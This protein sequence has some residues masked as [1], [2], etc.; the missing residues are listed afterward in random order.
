MKTTSFC[1]ALGLALTMTGLTLAA[2]AGPCTADGNHPGQ[3]IR[4]RLIKKF[5]TDGDGKLNDTERAAASAQWKQNHPDLFAK[6][7][8]NGDGNLSIEERKAART[9]IRTSTGGG[10]L[11]Y[12]K[13]CHA[14]GR[15]NRS[16]AMVPTEVL[17]P[18]DVAGNGPP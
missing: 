1:Y 6:I 14:T 10:G 13:F 3:T 4:Q 5:D 12:G 16:I 8:R 18:S 11:G 15:Q 7:D 2:N 17:R 9:I